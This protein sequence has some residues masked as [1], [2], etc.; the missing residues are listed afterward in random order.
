MNDS[1]NDFD[2]PSP[3]LGFG[4]P[5]PPPLASRRHT[6]R[7]VAI[8]CAIAFIGILQS[9]QPAQPPAAS[10]IP[11]Y[12]SVVAV[13]ILFVWFINKGIRSRGHSLLTL[14]GDRWRKPSSFAVDATL[15]IAFVLLLRGCTLLLHH[16]LG[17]SAAKASF[18]LPH[19][20]LESLIWTAVAI[21]SGVC[22][23]I[24]YR[25]YLQRQ[26]WS[27]IRSLPLA[28]LLQAIIFAAAHIYQ[29]WRPAL[30]TGVYGLSFGLLAAW[31]RS[32]VPGVF[33]HSLIDI[34]GGLLGR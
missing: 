27:L 25:G 11:L 13:Q 28:I 31:R 8:V 21:L 26:L 4:D 20:L 15:A 16:A 3:G 10:R 2:Q 9:R 23:E 5:P 17:Q 7:L 22:E 34:V 18:L 14:L 32:I 6:F 12:L 24:V 33:A 29:G 19:G 1:S 30:I